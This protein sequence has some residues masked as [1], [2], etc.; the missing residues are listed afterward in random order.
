MV[1]EAMFKHKI[2]DIVGTQ[3]RDH[4]TEKVC[5]LCCD[6]IGNG[7]EKPSRT[8]TKQ[9]LTDWRDLIIESASQS[10]IGVMELPSRRCIDVDYRGGMIPK[11]CVCWLGQEVEIRIAAFMRHIGVAQGV[12]PEMAAEKALGFTSKV[13]DKAIVLEEHLL[14]KAFRK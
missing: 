12:I 13:A 9:L 7:E 10:V 1:G 11:V 2:V 8:I 3:L 14:E 6:T 5:E 4:I